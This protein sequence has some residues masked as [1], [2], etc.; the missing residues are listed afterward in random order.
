MF[1]APLRGVFDASSPPRQSP[2]IL[3][4]PIP[5]VRFLEWKAH[6]L[7]NQPWKAAAFAFRRNLQLPR[8]SFQRHPAKD[9]AIPR[10]RM[11]G[12]VSRP[13]ARR[14]LLPEGLLLLGLRLTA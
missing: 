13:Y 10:I 12:A 9:G 7:P 6:R 1:H 14:G 11:F 8:F 4:S 2:N 5:V 3:L